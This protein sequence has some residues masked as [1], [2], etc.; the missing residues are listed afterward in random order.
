MT[1]TC[2]GTGNIIFLKT[3]AAIYNISHPTY[4]QYKLGFSNNSLQ[5]EANALT[6]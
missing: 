3:S 4:L 2:T 5:F 6:A 1:A